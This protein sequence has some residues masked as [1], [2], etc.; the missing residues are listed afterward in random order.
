MIGEGSL[1]SNHQSPISIILLIFSLLLLSACTRTPPVVKIGLV[2]PFEGRE[3]AI[4][5]DVIYSARLAVRE[6][7]EA[8][9]V[10]GYRVA[11]VALDDG[12]NVDFARETAV[13]LTLDPA[14]IA[15]VGHWQPETTAVAAP[16]YAA[17]GIPFV[18]MGERPF[19]PTDPTTLPSDFL[20]AYA[21]ITPFN[22][23]AGPYAATTYNAFQ[24]LWQAL[25][26]AT[27]PISRDSIAASLSSHE[28][29]GM[30]GSIP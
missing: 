13:S 5:Y 22:E 27:T 4:G 11:L 3:R 21:A 20:T 23:T 8:G 14:I 2:G 10:H 29:Q 30:T 9:G 25:A 1:I 28:Y 18:P 26:T 12:G 16:I 6:L 19:G 7:N 17:A 24:L 15:V